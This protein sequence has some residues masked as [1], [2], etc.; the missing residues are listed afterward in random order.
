MPITDIFILLPVPL[1]ERHLARTGISVLEQ[2]FNLHILDFSSC[3]SPQHRQK[4]GNGAQ[5]THRG[6]IQ[7]HDLDA[8]PALLSNARGG[9]AF[10][11]LGRGP[12]EQ[13]IREALQQSGIRRARIT[14]SAQP[15]SAVPSL[16]LR[17][18]AAFN[19][20]LPTRLWQKLVRRL[21]ERDLDPDTPPDLVVFTGEQSKTPLFA[22]TPHAVWA[23]H[24]D[25]DQFLSLGPAPDA[26]SKMAVFLDQDLAWHPDFAIANL[27]PPVTAERYYT[28]LNA[29]FDMLEQKTGL[30][31]VIA[32]HPQAHQP[33]GPHPLAGRQMVKGNTAAL[34]RDA[35]LVLA[36]E[37]TS[38]AF[39]ILW[40]K[41]LVFL[42]SGEINRSHMAIRI[43]GRAALF[44]APLIDLDRIEPSAI[45]LASWLR[46]DADSYAAYERAYLKIPG[47][48]DR[49]LWEIVATYIS[50]KFK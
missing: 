20:T 36:H 17:L 18:R 35:R 11:Y 38:L 2:H 27:K 8:L 41:P 12:Q 21:Q 5:F 44:H 19:R 39:A 48:E 24:Y 6:H 37:S 50:N 34:V 1:A 49:P 16:G 46:F 13:R 14:S 42:T 22:K 43:A 23:H 47:S 40:R 15:P 30:T 26:D 10:D 9:L 4:N 7:L 28:A 33:S 3:L 25:Y 32:T 29:F 45:D 31:V